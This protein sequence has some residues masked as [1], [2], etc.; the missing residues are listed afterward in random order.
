MF[1]A[2]LVLY[3]C[4][5]SSNSAPGAEKLRGGAENF[6]APFGRQSA[7]AQNISAP[8]YKWNLP[9]LKKILCT[10]LFLKPNELI[11]LQ[12]AEDSLYLI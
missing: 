5:P 7:P 12:I 2:P 8:P 6:F 1:F 4:P 9:L 11:L 3:F 10:P